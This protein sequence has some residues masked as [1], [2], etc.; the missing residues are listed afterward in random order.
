MHRQ[1]QVERLLVSFRATLNAEIT[2]HRGVVGEFAIEHFETAIERQRER[3]RLK[4]KSLADDPKINAEMLKEIE[5]QVNVMAD[6]TI[7]DAK[8]SGRIEFNTN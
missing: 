8:S 2:H 3:Y 4:F 5:R 1:K 7:R 6:D